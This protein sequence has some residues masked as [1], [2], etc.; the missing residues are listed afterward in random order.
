MKWQLY[1]KKAAR[2]KALRGMST[3]SNGAVNGPECRLAITVLMYPAPPSPIRHPPPHAGGLGEGGGGT[4]RRGDGVSQ[5]GSGAVSMVMVALLH[6][7]R[8][9]FAGNIV[10]S[11]EHM[12]PPTPLLTGTKVFFSRQSVFCAS[13]AQ[14]VSSC[15]TSALCTPLPWSAYILLVLRSP[16]GH[17]G[18][19]LHSLVS[20]PASHCA[21]FWGSIRRGTRAVR[22]LE[23][24]AWTVSAD[25]RG[26]V[27]LAPMAF[28]KTGPDTAEGTWAV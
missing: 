19:P 6:L 26:Y 20:E 10:H 2:T 18:F 16:T 5:R 24:V 11:T 28:P 15:C 4:A 25:L 27:L 9:C 13:G 8:T 21:T 14:W 1:K 23:V 17:G 22:K 12:C 3:V 7:D